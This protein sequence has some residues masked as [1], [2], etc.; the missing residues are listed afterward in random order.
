MY[1]GLRIKKVREYRNYTQVYMAKQLGI[2]Q[3]T[4]SKIENGLISL[5]PQR[6]KIIAEI[7]EI[8]ISILLNNEI[9]LFNLDYATK[10]DKLIIP[11]VEQIEGMVLHLKNELKKDKTTIH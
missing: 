1:T 8:N 11:Y 6:L 2:K 10:N 5:K 9:P 4:Y 7:L 3:N